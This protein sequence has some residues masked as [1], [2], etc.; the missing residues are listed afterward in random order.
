MASYRRIRIPNQAERLRAIDLFLEIPDT[1]YIYPGH[2]MD[3]T[4]EHLKALEREHIAFEYL[5]QANSHDSKG[6]APVH[7]RRHFPKGEASSTAIPCR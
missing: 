6:S 4:T 2:V 1:R 5:N 3:V 7:Q